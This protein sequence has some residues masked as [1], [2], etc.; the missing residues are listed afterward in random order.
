MERLLR[1]KCWQSPYDKPDDNWLPAILANGFLKF[2]GR[3]HLCLILL[4]FARYYEGPIAAGAR[5]Y[6]LTFGAQ[7]CN[8]TA[9][10]AVKH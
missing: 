7:R 5:G 4:K 8:S 9:P 2:N 1:A 3:E 6:M 10:L